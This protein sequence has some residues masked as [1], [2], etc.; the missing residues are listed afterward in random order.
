[1]E[2]YYSKFCTKIRSIHVYQN[3][4]LVECFIISQNH[5]SHFT[6]QKPYLAQLPYEDPRNLY[7]R[8][9]WPPTTTRP[10]PTTP[11]YVYP[12]RGQCSRSE[13]LCSSGECIPI[14]SH[15]DG[16]YDCRDYSDE[17]SCSKFMIYT[18]F[19]VICFMCS[20]IL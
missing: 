10:Y 11:R 20:R 3:S 17:R 16:R 9:A 4:L 19:S 12:P 2:N 7:T 14:S 5:I 18:F 8:P 6:F 15:C 1:M 13:W